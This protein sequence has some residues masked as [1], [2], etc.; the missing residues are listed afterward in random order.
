MSLRGLG[1]LV[2]CERHDV[3]REQ[4]GAFLDE[5]EAFRSGC[6]VGVDL[7]EQTAT[8]YPGTSNHHSVAGELK[9]LACGDARCWALAAEIKLDLAG[10]CAFAVLPPDNARSARCGHAT[11]EPFLFGPLMGLTE[12]TIITSGM[13]FDKY[14]NCGD[15][16]Y[17]T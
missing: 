8:V 3:C 15:K 10:L 17:R 7:D 5:R 11:T 12:A 14:E 6:V 13:R 4:V 16:L 9:L 2:E 1:T